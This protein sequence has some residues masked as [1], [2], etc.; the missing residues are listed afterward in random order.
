MLFYLI[1]NC[2]QEVRLVQLQSDDLEVV[3]E[4]C[5]SSVDCMQ[6]IN[7]AKLYQEEPCIRGTIDVGETIRR[8]GKVYIFGGGR[9]GS[10]SSKIESFDGETFER[11][12]VMKVKRVG[13]GIAV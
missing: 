4:F 10:W 6:R 13:H 3:A 7:E 5:T 9:P 2:I 8:G 11:K 1:T 12:G